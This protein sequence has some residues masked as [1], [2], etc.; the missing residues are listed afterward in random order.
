[1]YTLSYSHIL[2]TLGTTVRVGNYLY[3][4]NPDRTTLPSPI[5]P[6]NSLLDN[7]P[8]GRLKNLAKNFSSPSCKWETPQS[9]NLS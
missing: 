3:D 7:K 2:S 5:Y 9:A 4:T 6:N 1:M 8:H